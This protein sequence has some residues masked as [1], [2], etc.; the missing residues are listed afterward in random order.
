MACLGV[1]A[2]R[3]PSG[4]LSQCVCSEGLCRVYMEPFRPC[5]LDGPVEAKRDSGKVYGEGVSCKIPSQ[6]SRGE[7]A[8]RV[9]RRVE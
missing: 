6:P 9:K 1:P 7:G 8:L 2:G 5:F 4:L 3:W